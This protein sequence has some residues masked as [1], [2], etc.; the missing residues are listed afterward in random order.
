REAAWRVARLTSLH[1][2]V[3]AR[4]GRRTAVRRA[5]VRDVP[6][7]ALAHGSAGRGL[8]RA[9][10]LELGPRHAA[11]DGHA[12][13][14]CAGTPARRAP[15]RATDPALARRGEIRARDRLAHAAHLVP[16]V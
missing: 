1:H 11:V 15:L 9:A 10:R 5:R 4:G 16:A 12:A 2:A 8:A 7:G 3:A 14:D 6:P 13:H